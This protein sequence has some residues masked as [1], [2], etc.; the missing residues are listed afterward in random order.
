M[1]NFKI[2][3]AILFLGSI[4]WSCRTDEHLTLSKITKSKID[5]LPAKEYVLYEP[6]NNQN[7]PV[8]TVTWTETNFTFTDN[9]NPSPGAPVTYEL[10]ADLKGKEFGNPVVLAST[11]ELYANIFTKDLNQILL[12]KFDANPSKALDLELRVVA[13]YGLNKANF[14]ESENVLN[15]KITAYKPLEIIPA[16]YIIGDMNGWNNTN[17]DYIMYRNSNSL[18]D[19]TY[20]YTG[21]IAANTYYKFVPEESLGTYKAYTRKDDKIWLMKKV[22]AVLFITNLKGM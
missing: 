10:Q 11:N 20:T 13:Y 17:T 6:T 5:A 2:F 8:F 4:L 7:P 19:F 18:D 16:V 3:L 12:S 22:Q 14:T 21:R 1:K 15:V 9:E